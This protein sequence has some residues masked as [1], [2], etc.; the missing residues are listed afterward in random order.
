L[1]AP[2]TYL[3]QKSRPQRIAMTP[4][5]IHTCG[6]LKLR[7]IFALVMSSH[8]DGQSGCEVYRGYV[9]SAMRIATMQLHVFGEEVFNRS[10]NGHV[11]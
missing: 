2:L 6:T 8:A 10:H 11:N 5:C 9:A 1:M 7:V 3:L 4:S